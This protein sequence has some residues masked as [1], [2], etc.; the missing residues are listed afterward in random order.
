MHFSAVSIYAAY[1]LEV[2]AFLQ[3]TKAALLS[4]EDLYNLFV[5]FS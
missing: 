1:V 4:F 5:Q 3:K 2:V